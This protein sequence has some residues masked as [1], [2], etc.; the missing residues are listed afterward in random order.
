MNLFAVKAVELK[1]AAQKLIDDL[2]N[3]RTT[4]V[5]AKRR[6]TPRDY[7]PPTTVVAENRALSETDL[8]SPQLRGL[9]SILRRYLQSEDFT[10]NDNALFVKCLSE[11]IKNMLLSKLLDNRILCQPFASS[12]RVCA[13]NLYRF[14]ELLM[15]D[16][17]LVQHQPLGICS[18]ERIFLKARKNQQFCSPAC[19]FKTWTAKHPDYWQDDNGLLAQRQA[20]LKQKAPKTV[21]KTPGK[22]SAKNKRGKQ[23]QK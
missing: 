8:P 21:R 2:W 3:S 7:S 14:F 22:S 19:Q 17:D 16:S 6:R 11:P 4:Q 1:N 5:H 20:S 10:Q 9:F 15:A 18:C 13:E 12:S 23:S